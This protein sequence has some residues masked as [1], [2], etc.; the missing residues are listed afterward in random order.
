[1]R[2]ILPA[3]GWQGPLYRH[4]LTRWISPP[5]DPYIALLAWAIAL[6]ALWWLMVFLMVKRRIHL[7]L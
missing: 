6:V 1:M 7:K 3:L 2:I 4:L 5:A